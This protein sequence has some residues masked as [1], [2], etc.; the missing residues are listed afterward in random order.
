MSLQYGEL[1]P[2]SDWDRFVSLGHPSEFQRFSRLASVTARYSGSGRQPNFAVLNRGHHLC[3]AGR[4]SRWALA[5]ILV[6]ICSVPTQ[7]TAKHRAK[8]SCPLSVVERRRCSNKADTRNPL[9]FSGM[10]QTGK[11]ISA[12]NGKKFTILQRHV[13]EILLFNNFSFW[14]S[15]HA[16]DVQM[17]PDKFVRWCPDGEF[18]AIFCVLY[19]QRSACSTFQT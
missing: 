4:P 12:A 18:L 14:L 11:P 13:E 1:R 17:Q 9:K 19:F 8:F 10:P 15:T 5:H 16:L 7:E 3:S 6:R 2:T